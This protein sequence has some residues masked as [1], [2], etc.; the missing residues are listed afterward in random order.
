VIIRFI[1]THAHLNVSEF[2]NDR[3]VVIE[4]AKS[5]GV[6][7]IITIGTDLESSLEAVKIASD[8]E[9]IYAA[10]GFDP[11]IANSIKKDDITKLIELSKNSRV[12]AIGEIG[13]D[14]YHEYS[15]SEA[16]LHVLIWQLQ[17]ATECRLPVIIHSRNADKEMPVVLR[18]WLGNSE[19]LKLPAP[20]VIHCFNGGID[21]VKQ[22]L[23][24]GFYIAFGAYIGYPSSRLEDTIR[25]IPVDRLLVETDCPFLPPQ[26]LRGKRNEPSYIPQ[27]VDRLAVIRGE[28]PETVAQYTTENAC[29][30]FSID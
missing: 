23:E 12:K 15:S 18:Q 1:D 13:L 24:M 7:T 19:N 8:H 5:V 11:H 10:V 27:I 28:S 4:R 3:E 21:I 29:R 17:I 16:Q 6:N 26:S 22:Y 25:Y 9:G 30:F 20:G 14:Y 2:D